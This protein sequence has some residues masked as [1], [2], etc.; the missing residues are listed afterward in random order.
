VR[1]T[2]YAKSFQKVL[3][4]GGHSENHG[5]AERRGEGIGSAGGSL[6]L[7]SSRSVV[8]DRDSNR[9]SANDRDRNWDSN[10]NRSSDGCGDRWSNGSR[11]SS[12]AALVIPSAD[13]TGSTSA[14]VN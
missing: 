5:H 1:E 10:G 13:S 4:H 7:G 11:K 6:C 9:S 2:F 3:P 12:Y 14:R 8:G